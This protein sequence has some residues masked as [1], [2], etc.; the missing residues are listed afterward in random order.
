MNINDPSGSPLRVTSEGRANVSSVSEPI[1]RHVNREFGKAWSVSFFDI[2]PT[3]AFD[4][5]FY[6]K[7]TGSADL[8]M[9]GIGISSTVTGSLEVMAVSGTPTFSSGVDLTPVSR[10]LGKS[11]IVDATIKS[12]IDIT[13]LSNDGIVGH[14]KISA[15]DTTFSLTDNSTLII[16]QGK[17]VALRWSEATGVLT[18]VIALIEVPEEHD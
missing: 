17:A 14:T 12:S 16:P 1:D 8:T 3:G 13:G 2:D 18:G 11:P 7:N 5:F 9:T 6:L 15:V 4:Y 10:N